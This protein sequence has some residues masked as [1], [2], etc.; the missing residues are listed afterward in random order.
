MP[1]LPGS[2]PVPV[3]LPSSFT[4]TPKPELTLCL[5]SQGPTGSPWQVPSDHL[6][7]LESHCRVGENNRVPRLCLILQGHRDTVN[8][9]QNP[10]VGA[11]LDSHT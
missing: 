1:Q 7:T 3:S 4:P 11:G 9:Y 6:V 5:Y 10:Q 8:G 2:Q